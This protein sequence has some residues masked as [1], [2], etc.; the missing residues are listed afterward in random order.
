MVYA[1]LIF[2]LFAFFRTAF[3]EEIELKDLKGNPVNIFEYYGKST[4][5][6]FWTTWCPY[7]RTEIRQLDKI[8]DQAKS[9]GISI[10]GIN[11]GESNQKVVKFFKNYALKLKILLDNEGLLADRYNVIGVP[12]YVFLDKNGKMVLTEHTLPAY[13]KNLLF[14]TDKK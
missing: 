13:Y 8:Y 10:I 3:A 12:T 11:I 5:L 4:I 14:K 6:F 1:V 7:C 9:E 2:L